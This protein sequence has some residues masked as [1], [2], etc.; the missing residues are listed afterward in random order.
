MNAYAKWKYTFHSIQTVI[1]ECKLYC[2]RIL[3]SATVRLR[4]KKTKTSIRL[5]LV[6]QY[7]MNDFPLCRFLQRSLKAD[8]EADN[9]SRCPSAHSSSVHANQLLLPYSVPR[10][11]AVSPSLGGIPMSPELAMVRPDFNLS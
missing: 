5:V 1:F 11:L 4:L 2:K 7:G 9:V 8:E 6:V 3:S 10:T